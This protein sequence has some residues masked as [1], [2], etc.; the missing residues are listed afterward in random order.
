MK[1]KLNFLRIKVSTVVF[2]LK[3][4]EAIRQQ[5]QDGCGQ[6]LGHML[7][8]E[9]DFLSVLKPQTG[10]PGVDP[11]KKLQITTSMLKYLLS[12]F[13]KGQYFGMRS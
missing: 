13:W 8:Q 3:R 2:R 12:P 4:E 1:R 10:N 9:F 6:L 11:N 5:E 7:H